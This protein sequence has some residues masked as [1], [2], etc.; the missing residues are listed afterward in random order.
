MEV[1]Q[2]EVGKSPDYVGKLGNWITH[3]HV[4]VA[5]PRGQ[6]DRSTIIANCID[7]CLGQLHY[8]P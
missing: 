2:L 6:A 3:A 4:L 7:H 5:S 1:G 8:K